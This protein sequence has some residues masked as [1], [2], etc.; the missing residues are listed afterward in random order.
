[1]RYL[2][3]HFEEDWFSGQKLAAKRWPYCK[4]GAGY[5][6]RSL[7]VNARG[8]SSRRYYALYCELLQ[9]SYI[10]HRSARPPTSCDSRQTMNCF[11]HS[12]YHP[13]YGTGR[14]KCVLV[15]LVSTVASLA[16]SKFIV[17]LRAK[18]AA[19]EIPLLF[20]Y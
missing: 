9:S 1:M 11:H 19:G 6:E 13:K 12:F 14:G 2:H 16:N 20:E 4:V 18:I 15:S 3:H 5:T 17:I 8:A 7:A 10:P